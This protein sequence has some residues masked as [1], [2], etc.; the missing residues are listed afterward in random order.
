M[1]VI[2]L[3]GPAFIVIKPEFVRD[4]LEAVLDGE[5]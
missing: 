4:G 5:R 2:G 3:A 1:P